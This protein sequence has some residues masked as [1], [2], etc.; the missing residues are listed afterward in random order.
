M[1]LLVEPMSVDRSTSIYATT[2]ALELS[3]A[4]FRAYPQ[5]FLARCKARTWLGHQSHK[6][7]AICQLASVLAL[8]VFTPF[9][10]KG[11]RS[12]A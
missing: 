3:Q 12:L 2:A 10:L 8:S 7:L 11:V 4:C 5:P 1:R 6:D 9:Q